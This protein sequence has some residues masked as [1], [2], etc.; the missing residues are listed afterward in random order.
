MLRSPR[1]HEGVHSMQIDVVAKP[2]G[3]A[4]VAVVFAG[5]GKKLLGLGAAFG[6]TVQKALAAPAFSARRGEIVDVLGANGARRILVVGVGNPKELSAIR[7][8]KI[9]GKIAAHLL[10]ARE[11]KAQ[12]LG[13]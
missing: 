8:R 9:G 6:K 12:I 13:G 7:A 1:V 10:Q 11:P 3:S 2:A 4:D 5:E